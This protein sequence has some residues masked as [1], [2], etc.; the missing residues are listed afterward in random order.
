MQF[1]SR[2]KDVVR[3]RFSCGYAHVFILL[4]HIPTKWDCMDPCWEF[5]SGDDAYEMMERRRADAL[6]RQPRTYNFNDAAMNGT[7]VDNS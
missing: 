1:S 5:I 4:S 7:N 6:E 2:A 3:I